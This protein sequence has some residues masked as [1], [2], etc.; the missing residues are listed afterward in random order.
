M[1]RTN[2]L[3]AKYMAKSY[4]ET[5]DKV[6]KDGVKEG[7]PLQHKCGMSKQESSVGTKT[8]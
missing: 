3:E 6:G 7:E 1:R 8:R 2:W 4:T 5:E